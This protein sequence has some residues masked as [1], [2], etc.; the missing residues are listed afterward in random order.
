MQVG[1]TAAAAEFILGGMLPVFSYQY[2]GFDP[3]TALRNL[4][5]DEGVNGLAALNHFPGPPLW[6]IQLLASVP[7]VMMGAVNLFFVP[8]SISFGRRPV[9]LAS[10]V[11]AVIGA[12]W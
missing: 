2:A 7:I 8:L 9:V 6:R 11:I 3:S 4:H 1:S 5:I 12:V 10:G